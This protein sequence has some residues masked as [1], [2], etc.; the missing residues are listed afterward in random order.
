MIHDRRSARR[1]VTDPSRALTGLA[2]PRLLSA[3]EPVRLEAVAFG[4][5]P[6]GPSALRDALESR[7]WMQR[8]PR[9]KHAGPGLAAASKYG[10]AAPVNLR[11]PL[12]INFAERRESVTQHVAVSRQQLISLTLVAGLQG[13]TV[14]QVSIRAGWRRMLLTTVPSCTFP[15]FVTM[16]KLIASLRGFFV[17]RRTA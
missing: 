13:G 4:G 2:L 9:P 15:D 5:V 3:G 6:P 8:A 1:G 7:R 17:P 12:V 11:H 16:T 14:Y 10:K